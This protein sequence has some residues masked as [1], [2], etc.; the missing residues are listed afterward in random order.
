MGLDLSGAELSYRL[1]LLFEGMGM[2]D[3][4]VVEGISHAYVAKGQLV[5]G[6]VKDK[7][8]GVAVWDRPGG[9]DDLKVPWASHTWP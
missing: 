5:S 4:N 2:E 9:E 1:C 8:G 6:Q 7:E 3:W